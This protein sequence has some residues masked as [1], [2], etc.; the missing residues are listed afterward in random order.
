MASLL[1]NPSPSQ[2][3]PRAKAARL[4]I[5]ISPPNPRIGVSE[6]RERENT[7]AALPR[8]LLHNRETGGFDTKGKG[9]EPICY[10][11]NEENLQ[12]CEDRLV[13]ES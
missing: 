12:G 10:Q 5:A 13:G 7:P 4:A 6:R 9:R 3:Q 8:L 2:L 1:A 11:I